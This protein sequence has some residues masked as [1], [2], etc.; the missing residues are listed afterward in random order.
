MQKSHAQR[1]YY[2]TKEKNVTRP[3]CYILTIIVTGVVMN[4]NFFTFSSIHQI[5][6]IMNRWYFMILGSSTE[7]EQHEPRFSSHV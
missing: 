6:F 1:I 2:C 5:L 4:A 7:E 3:Y